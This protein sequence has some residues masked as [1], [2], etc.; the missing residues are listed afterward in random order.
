[1]EAVELAR[2]EYAQ[3]RLLEVDAL[4]ASIDDRELDP[5]AIRMKREAADARNCFEALSKTNGASDWRPSVDWD[6]ISVKFRPEPTTRFASVLVSH[7][8]EAP[9]SMVMTVMN[10]VSLLPSWMP[11]FM[12]FEARVLK[13][14]SR[15]RML[16]WMRTRVPPPFAPRE[17]V[18]DA[19]AVDLLHKDQPAIMV[20][21]RNANPEDW[22]DV[23]LMAPPDRRDGRAVAASIILAGA[24]I[25][26]VSLAESR[27]T[28]VMNLDPQLPYL[29]AWLFNWVNRKLV[30]YAFDAFRSK[31]KAVHDSGLPDEYKA[32]IESKP[33]V[34][35]EMKRR[36][37]PWEQPPN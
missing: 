18:F 11:G 27:L 10:E 31:V 15:F 1:M 22:P 16:L 23:E 3:E 7:G 34:Y 19:Q 12:G 28:N 20:V 37:A 4:L 25:T 36:L 33:E 8:L 30:W 2:A 9:L 26:P 13:H 32:L 24:L 17:L 29:P 6:G 35:D 21:V 14:V 5:D